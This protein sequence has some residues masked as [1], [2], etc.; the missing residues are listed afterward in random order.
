MAKIRQSCG[1]R[2]HLLVLCAIACDSMSITKNSD[3]KK[4]AKQFGWQL[5]TISQRTPIPHSR[6]TFSSMAQELDRLIAAQQRRCQFERN[7]LL[8]L[9]A[10]RSEHH[11]VAK[12]RS[13]VV[14]QRVA[15]ALET[16]DAALEIADELM[17]EMGNHRK[18]VTFLVLNEESE[19]IVGVDDKQIPAKKGQCQQECQAARPFT[20]F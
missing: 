13:S 16:A 6:P 14:S 10:E 15:T 19:Q 4:T 5:L 20:I 17:L 8:V 11:L 9:L 12:D 1:I 2:Q 3:K 7:Q 18:R